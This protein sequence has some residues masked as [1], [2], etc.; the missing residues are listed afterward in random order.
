MFAP[1]KF[2]DLKAYEP[3]RVPSIRDLFGR[4]GERTKL[5]KYSVSDTDNGTPIPVISSKL[6]EIT[7]AE[8]RLKNASKSEDK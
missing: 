8:N 6:N 1:P 7:D 2:K 4:F 5:S 3:K